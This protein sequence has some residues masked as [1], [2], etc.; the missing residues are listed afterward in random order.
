VKRRL[1]AALACR[2][3]G[4]RL[5]AKPLQK[6]HGDQ[7]I[8]DQIIAALK[9]LPAID[10]IVLGIA[11]GRA[12]L[13][14][15][16]VAEAHGIAHVIGNEDDVLM[17]LIQC[18]RAGKASDVFR[19][20]T[21]CPWFA[22][23]LLGPVWREH[24]A[25]G[26]DISVTDRLPEGLNFEIY[27]L[28]ALQRAHER[29]TSKD[30][31]EYCSNYPRTHPGEF[32]TTVFLPRRAEQRMDLRVTVDYPE[33]LMVAREI[34]RACASS[35][36]LVPARDIIRFLDARADLQALV[37]AHVVPQPLWSAFSEPLELDFDA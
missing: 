27:S 35:M 29:G 23:G 9:R 7:S 36:P 32:R 10:E 24:Q 18:G 22:Y 33:D 14:F 20:T 11:E 26:N 4:T 28:E 13:A 17:R 6:L 15:L 19:V 5:Y 30:R 16:D 2:N 31:S 21:E 34:A 25:R 1:V 8:L 12:N 3:S 37:A